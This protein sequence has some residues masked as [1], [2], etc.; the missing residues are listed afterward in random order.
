MQL[1]GTYDC[2]PDVLIKMY[3]C[4]EKVGFFLFQ[5]VGSSINKWVCI[6]SLS[7]H[8]LGL[9][10]RHIHCLENS[11]KCRLNLNCFGGFVFF[12]IPVL[13]EKLP[14]N[15]EILLPS[16]PWRVQ[17]ET[18]E[19]DPAGKTT[20]LLLLSAYCRTVHSTGLSFACIPA[21]RGS[22][23]LLS[24]QTSAVKRTKLTNAVAAS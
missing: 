14:E 21:W 3:P 19:E 15:T 17:W 13:Q 16:K 2:L 4:K 22:R 1:R 24:Y 23:F 18:Q 20:I 9:L 8:T 11:M 6:C 12:P 7:S 10:Q 5:L